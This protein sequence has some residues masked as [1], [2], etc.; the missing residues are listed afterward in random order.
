VLV[1]VLGLRLPESGVWSTAAARHH[2]GAN[3]AL[4]L[5][6]MSLHTKG[7]QWQA[8]DRPELLVAVALKVIGQPLVTCLAGRLLG[9][10][11]H[12]LL[13]A[14][15]CAALP[16]A[17]NVSAYAHQYELDTKLP[18]DAVL[19]STVLS[20]VTLSGVTLLMRS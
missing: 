7:S 6:G 11:G 12:L 19:L 13:A 17:Q 1:S 2:R 8:G 4:L 20:M 15:L 16:T 5:V 9:L 14:V 10:D 3:R 18:R